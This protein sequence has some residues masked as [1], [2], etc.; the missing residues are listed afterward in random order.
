MTAAP[1]RFSKG[2]EGAAQSFGATRRPWRSGRRSRFVALLGRFPPLDL[3][4]R[5]GVGLFFAGRAMGFELLYVLGGI[6][7]LGAAAIGVLLAGTIFV[8]SVIRRR[9]GIED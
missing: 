7:V 4:R 5:F 8:D 1:S 6:L 3:A 2:R 9:A